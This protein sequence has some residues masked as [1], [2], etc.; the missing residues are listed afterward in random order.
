MTLA[1][2]TEPIVDAGRIDKVP[3]KLDETDEQCVSRARKR[4]A[5]S[6]YE[7]TGVTLGGD[8]SEVEYTYDLDGRRITERAESMRAMV[9]RLKA[10]QAAGRK[11]TLL[12][13]EAATGTSARHAAIAY[14]GVGGQERRLGTLRWRP[15][16]RTRTSRGPG[17]ALEHIRE[18]ASEQHIEV[19]SSTPPTR[20]PR[21]DGDLRGVTRP[22]CQIPDLASRRG[23]ALLRYGTMDSAKSMNLLAVAHN[24]RKQG[25]RVLLVKPRRHRF[26]APR[27]RRAWARGMPTC[28]D[29]DTM[30]IRATSRPRLHPR[31]RG[32]VLAPAVIEDLRRITVDPGVPVICYGLRTDFRTKLF[33]GAQ[34]L[35]E[36]AD[37]I[38]EV[39]V[40]C[41]Y[42]AKKAICN[43]RFVNGTPTVR[44]PQI[45]LGAE[46]TYAPVCWLH[47]DEATRQVASDANASV[48]SARAV[49]S[50]DLRGDSPVGEQ[51]G[52]P[53]VRVNEASRCR[54]HLFRVLVVVLDRLGDL[55]DRTI[56][57]ADRRIRACGRVIDVR[58]LGRERLAT[59]GELDRELP[60]TE[61]VRVD[62]R[63]VPR[64]D[65]RGAG[66]AGALRRF[67]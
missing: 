25:K 24:Y 45:Q 7:V 56:H 14:R 32:A 22:R 1:I 49:I 16:R 3:C 12:R 4:P 11:V 36:L 30:L 2:T 31:R 52:E 13:G 50:S 28:V 55:G 6:Y 46:E 23:E 37:G 9:A 21:R 10:L 8:D 41:Q 48:P 26:G 65:E 61:R 40:T 15:T 35:M 44:G 29:Q 38:E 42:C 63:V 60:V 47:Y 39:K 27:S 17:R 53:R 58:I 19:R 18:V 20:P 51:R 33:P 34:R 54:L 64:H 57:L 59:V 66:F 43:L 67:G 62:T 5:P